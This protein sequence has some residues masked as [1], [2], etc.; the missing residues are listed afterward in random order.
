MAQT[1][2]LKGKPKGL[3]ERTLARVTFEDVIPSERKDYF[4]VITTKN[5][6]D[7]PNS[8]PL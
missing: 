4:F 1:L 7:V 3:Y 5:S 6:A 2:R 8:T